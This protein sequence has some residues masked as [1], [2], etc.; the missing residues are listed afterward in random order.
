MAGVRRIGLWVLAGAACGAFGLAQSNQGSGSGS[1]AG[2]LTDSYS[3]PLIGATVTLHNQATGAEARTTTTKNGAYRFTGLDAGE[4]TL[5]AES[6]QLGR[7]R[8]D[9]IV[10]AAGHEARVQAA[11]ELERPRRVAAQMALDRKSVV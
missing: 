3:T 4:Y 11:I 7:G 5:E 9:G 6:A 10:V 8:V 1:L 2:K